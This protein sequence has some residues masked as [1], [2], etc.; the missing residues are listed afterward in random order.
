[1]AQ[2]YD[3]LF[4]P[5]NCLLQL[6]RAELQQKLNLP[7]SLFDTGELQLPQKYQNGKHFICT[8]LVD[9]SPSL[10]EEIER[11]NQAIHELYRTVQLRVNT[12]MRVALDLC[13]LE[14]SSTVRLRRQFGHIDKS[15]QPPRLH[16]DLQSRTSALYA[17]LF[18]AYYRSEMR[19]A[20]YYQLYR[21]QTAGEMG[22]I[23]QKNPVEYYEPIL[24]LSTDYGENAGITL[25]CL[26]P[27]GI[28]DGTGG[29]EPVSLD[30]FVQLMLDYKVGKNKIALFLGQYGGYNSSG[31]RAHF[32]QL[33]RCGSTENTSAVRSIQA[34]QVAEQYR[35][36]LENLK[37]TIADRGG[38]YMTD[39]DF[40]YLKANP[41]EDQNHES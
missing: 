27:I 37:N 28:P 6:I 33:Q 23:I 41:D 20:Q 24:H 1:M 2:N 7:D 15:E 17:A 22:E 8:I 5:D 36:I 10:A 11:I 31:N 29:R 12:D 13:I 19:K 14:F 30:S 35:W 4:Y 40:E 18:V 39:D 25:D 32:E 38:D 34:E 26:H 16:T 9:T 21:R 3:H